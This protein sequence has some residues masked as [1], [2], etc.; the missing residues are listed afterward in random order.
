MK[1][2]IIA[3]LVATVILFVWQTLS[4]MVLP[5]HNGFTKY[6]PA[7]KEVLTVLNNSLT[8]DGMYYMPGKDP[9]KTYTAEEE[10]KYMQECVGKPVAMVF[11][12]KSFPG[13]QPTVMLKGVLLNMVAVLMAIGIVNMAV[14]A[15]A[16]PLARFLSVLSLAVFSIFQGALMNWNWW[17]F[18][19]H[20]LR[21]SVIDM[22]VGW[23]LCGLF[24]SWYLGK[25]KKV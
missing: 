19:W 25:A 24:L 1:K 5:V 12:S 16:T 7:D 21:G 2:N 13:M 23:S 11:Y 6:S 14:K 3:L 18:P 9:A 8:E 22:L 17:Y 4:W 10:E 20:F 15:G